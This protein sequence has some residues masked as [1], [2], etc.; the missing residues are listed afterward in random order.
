MGTITT[1]AFEEAL[2]R[3]LRELE[4][5]LDKYCNYHMYEEARFDVL[6]NGLLSKLGIEQVAIDVAQ[7]CTCDAE[8]LHGCLCTD[9]IIPLPLANAASGMNT[10]TCKNGLRTDLLPD[11]TSIIQNQTQT[12]TSC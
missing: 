4:Q 11:N 12:D 9:A 8:S 10:T 7:S 5:V 1:S 6:C 2:L 3:I